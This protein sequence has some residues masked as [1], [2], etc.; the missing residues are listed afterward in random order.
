MKIGNLEFKPIIKNQNMVPK[1]IYDFVKDWDNKEEKEEFMVAEI[2]PDYKDG[3]MLC[4][5]Y[6]ILCISFSEL[7]CYIHY[8]FIHIKL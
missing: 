3:N 7:R 2:N 8:L 6:N 1:C 5:E 4:E